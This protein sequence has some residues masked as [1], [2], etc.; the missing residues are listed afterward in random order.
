[1][2]TLSPFIS[3]RPHELPPLKPA[4]GM[5]YKGMLLAILSQL[6]VNLDKGTAEGNQLILLIIMLIIFSG[7]RVRIRI[8]IMTM[9][10]LN[11][12]GSDG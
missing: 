10:I 11:E 5:R 3:E 8:S 12:K 4:P 9:K 6:S 7:G 1:M 2:A